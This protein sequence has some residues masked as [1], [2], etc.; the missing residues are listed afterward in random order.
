LGRASAALHG[1]AASV[2]EDALGQP[3]ELTLTP[4]PQRE[5]QSVGAVGTAT[6]V[7]RRDL[8]GARWGDGEL[9]RG[10]LA[11]E[12]L[13]GRVEVDEAEAE[14]LAR[15]EPRGRAQVEVTARVARAGG[16]DERLRA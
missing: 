12:Q 16:G 4:R 10:Q 9:L 7:L 15:T 1:L 8:Q 11:R 2:R 6:A 13:V 3:G 14:I 5:D